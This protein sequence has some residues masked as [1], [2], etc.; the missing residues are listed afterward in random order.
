[1]PEAK[2]SAVV[3]IDPYVAIA[4][5][6]DYVHLRELHGLDLDLSPSD[7]HMPNPYVKETDLS[8]DMPGTGAM[9]MR[10]RTVG[11]NTMLT[12][13]DVAGRVDL[14]GATGTPIRAGVTQ[15]YVFVSA[16]DTR[17]G[18]PERDAEIATH[19][20]AQWA[21]ISQLTKDDLRVFKGLQFHK[22]A[23]TPA[24]AMLGQWLRFAEEFPCAVPGHVAST[25]A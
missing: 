11:T 15:L 25:P 13:A 1:M 22:G 18:T 2:H 24:D 23:M 3:A 7:I 19:I 4:N 14:S 8:W 21:W 17:D 10:T 6:Y 9:R 20:G 12:R 5:V 16:P